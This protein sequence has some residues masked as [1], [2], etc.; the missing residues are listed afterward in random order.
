MKNL[1]KNHK[2]ALSISEVGWSD[3]QSKLEYKSNVYGRTFIKVPPHNATQTCSVCGYVNKGAKKLTLKNRE[4][5]CPK[6]GTYHVRDYNAAK[7]I[8]AKGLA[9]LCDEAPDCT[10][11]NAKICP[12]HGSSPG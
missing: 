4:W 7:N 8:L 9:I 11:G 1:L 10:S 12:G 6:C 2:L 5:V 3:F